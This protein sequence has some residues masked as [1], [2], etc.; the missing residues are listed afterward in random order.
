MTFYRGEQGS[1]KFHNAGSTTV[2]VASTRS[3][4]LTL[5]KEVLNVDTLGKT[6]SQ[7]IG[8][9]VSGTGSAEVIY[10]DEASQT[11]EFV[12]MVNSPNDD[13]AAKFELLLVD[14]KSVSFN[15]LINTAEIT[16]TIGELSVINVSFTT[17]DEITTAY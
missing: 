11:H 13:S 6:Y 12:D 1:V 10:S 2:T 9:I 7:N 4:S 17:H 3:W 16:A 8:G 5:E 15:G 14:G